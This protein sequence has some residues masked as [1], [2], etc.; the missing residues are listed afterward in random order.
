MLKLHNNIALKVQSGYEKDIKRPISQPAFR[1]NDGKAVIF[2][3][4]PFCDVC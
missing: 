3:R 4:R 2:R 1:E